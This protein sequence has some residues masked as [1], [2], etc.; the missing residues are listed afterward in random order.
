MQSLGSFTFNL[1]QIVCFAYFIHHPGSAACAYLKACGVLL[2]GFFRYLNA[3]L[4]LQCGSF[5][6]KSL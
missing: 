1:E 3:S 6:V 2:M 4:I 5:T